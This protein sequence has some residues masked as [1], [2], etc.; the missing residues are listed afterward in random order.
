MQEKYP[1]WEYQPL[2]DHISEAY[3]LELTKD[4]MDEI[5][6]KSAIVIA[7]IDGHIIESEARHL[8]AYFEQNPEEESI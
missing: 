1:G 7:T 4:E 8:E 6:S 2:F 5:L 3:G